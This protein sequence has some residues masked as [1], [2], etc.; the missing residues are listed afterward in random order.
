[1]STPPL[2]GSSL[3]PQIPSPTQLIVP[4][5][6]PVNPG[7]P[8][9]ATPVVPTKSY[10][11]SPLSYLRPFPG[12]FPPEM[13]DEIIDQLRDDVPSLRAC[14]L[15]CHDW[16]VRSRRHL[17]RKIEI[18][19]RQGS[20]GVCSY[21]KSRR[22]LILLVQS[23]LVDLRSPYMPFLKQLPNL[24]RLTLT[25]HAWSS[26]DPPDAFH[27]LL[28][29]CF[30]AHLHIHTLILRNIHLG[31]PRILSSLI[32]S[33]PCLTHLVCDRVEIRDMEGPAE[34]SS[35]VV[36]S[37]RRS[38]FKKRTKLRHLEVSIIAL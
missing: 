29:S 25:K 15:T 6:Q 14:A 2:P 22:S 8:P 5:L 36:D 1:M 35:Q 38:N 30:R 13:C 33:L 7:L 16:Q 34:I 4:S 24:R 10:F 17:L 21:L 37:T 11:T 32:L 28:L 31:S 20:R 19:G 26:S 27:P 23:A 3:P 12:R 9:D 18:Y